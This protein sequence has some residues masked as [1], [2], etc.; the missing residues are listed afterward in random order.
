MAADF[1]HGIE[2]I[3]INDGARPIRRARMSVIGLIGTAPAADGA[4]WPYNTPVAVYGNSVYAMGIAAGIQA[5][6]GCMAALGA[7]RFDMAI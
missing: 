2:T 1:L 5:A 4:L 7:Q 6:P 3:E